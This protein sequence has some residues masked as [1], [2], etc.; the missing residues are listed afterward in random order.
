MYLDTPYGFG[1]HP[2]TVMQ[3]HNFQLEDGTL[4]GVGAAAVGAEG[5][6]TIVGGSG[7]Y[8]GATGSYVA[9]QDPYETGGDGTARFKFNLALREG[10]NGSR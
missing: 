5:V 7:R 10:T 4:V 3:I 1:S 8:L 6:F 2:A 9:T